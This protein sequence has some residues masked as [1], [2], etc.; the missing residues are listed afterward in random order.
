MLLLPKLIALRF[1]DSIDLVIAP[2][3]SRISTASKDPYV[4]SVSPSVVQ[5][6]P[7]ST[8]PS[9]CFVNAGPLESTGSHRVGA[10]S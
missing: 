6:D 9:L 3:L 5:L 1:F 7:H 8:M 10:E 2:R 4:R